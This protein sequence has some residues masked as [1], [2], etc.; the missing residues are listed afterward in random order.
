MRHEYRGSMANPDWEKIPFAM[1]EVVDEERRILMPD[2][3]CS[4]LGS[5]LECSLASDIGSG[6]SRFDSRGFME[7]GEWQT[8]I[9]QPT[10]GQKRSVGQQAER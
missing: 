10:M 5:S 2:L 7:P 6:F 3:T 8:L 9:M 1:L 4:G